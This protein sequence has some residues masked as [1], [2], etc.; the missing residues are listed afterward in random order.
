MSSEL[1]QEPEEPS[2]ITAMSEEENAAS[3]FQNQCMESVA[4]E[5][6]RLRQLVANLSSSLKAERTRSSSLAAEKRE[7]LQHVRVLERRLARILDAGTAANVH[8]ALWGH[9]TRMHAHT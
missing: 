9:G 7:A 4:A 6:E 5:N 1:V 2:L 3:F 8:E